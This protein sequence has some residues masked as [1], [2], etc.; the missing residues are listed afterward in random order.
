MSK[1]RIILSAATLL[2]GASAAFGQ[3][4]DGKGK[5]APQPMSFFVTSTGGGKGAD[6]GGLAGKPVKVRFELK[7]ADLFA[8]QFQARP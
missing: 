8:F 2:I 4:K 1:F 3:A 5:A 7:D 6:L